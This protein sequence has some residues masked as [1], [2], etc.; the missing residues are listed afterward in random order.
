MVL[1]A[2]RFYVFCARASDVPAASELPWSPSTPSRTSFNIV[3]PG[4]LIHLA[5]L[6]GALHKHHLCLFI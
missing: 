5:K 1:R 3:V 2:S 6:L 4:V